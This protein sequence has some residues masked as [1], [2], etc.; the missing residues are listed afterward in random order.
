MLKGEAA[1]LSGFIYVQVPDIS[2]TDLIPQGDCSLPKVHGEA[3]EPNVAFFELETMQHSRAGLAITQLRVLESTGFPANDT[4]FTRFAQD[5]VAVPF[6]AINVIAVDVARG[7][8]W[9]VL[10]NRVEWSTIAAG[11]AVIRLFDRLLHVCFIQ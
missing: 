7:K 11:I 6:D 2:T 4:I 1:R 9:K 3:Y 8:V 5:E 10:E